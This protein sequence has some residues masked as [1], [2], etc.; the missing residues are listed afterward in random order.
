Y[1]KQL[2]QMQGQ[3]ERWKEVTGPRIRGLIAKYGE[4]P[5]KAFPGRAAI[6]VKLLGLD[7]DAIYAVYEKPGSMKIGHYL[8]GTRIPIRSDDDF[9]ALLSSPPVLLNLAWHISSEI[10]TYM[11]KQ[12]Y[13]GVIVNILEPQDFGE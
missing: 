10:S 8:P 4:L 12:G 11:R 7:V 6:L 5:G 3:V 9:R 2:R 1:G 13:E